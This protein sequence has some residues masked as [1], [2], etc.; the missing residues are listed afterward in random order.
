MVAFLRL[1]AL[2]VVVAA[3]CSASLDSDWEIEQKFDEDVNDIFD[4]FTAQLNELDEPKNATSAPAPKPVL[5]DNWAPNDKD[6]GPDDAR[7]NSGLDGFR[8]VK[9]SPGP[10]KAAAKKETDDWAPNDKDDGTDDN[11]DNS[12]LTGYGELLKKQEKLANATKAAGSAK[13]VKKLAKPM[14]DDWAPNDKDDGTDDDR[15]NSA[16]TGYGEHVKKPTNSTATKPISSTSKSASSSKAAP[17]GSK[18][19]ASSSASKK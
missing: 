9:K 2:C 13:P 6:D 11:R 19:A 17:A 4:D 1:A 14:S 18:A 3:L 16:L 8:P 15:D 12:A 5:D 7:D 10:K